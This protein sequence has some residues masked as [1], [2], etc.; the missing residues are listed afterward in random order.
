MAYQIDQK[1]IHDQE[2]MAEIM[3]NVITAMSSLLQRVSETN[4]DL[5]RPFREH[6]RISAFNAVT[7]P[8][9]SIRSYMERIFKYAD[10]SDSCYIVAYIYLDR[11]IQKQPLL[12]IDSSNV[13]RLIITSVLVSAKFM[14][15]LCYN[16]AF[17]AKVGGITTEEMNLLEL[18]FL[19]GIGFQLNVTISTYNDYCSSLQREMVMRTMYSP[20]LEPAFLVRS[21]HKNLLKNLYDEDHRNSQVTSAV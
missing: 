12:P 9:I 10:C 18:D 14:D 8:S 19:F 2:P 13:H 21:F 15:D 7:K 5:S 20:L 4:D 6:K 17:Y 11:F 3:P 16:N 1:M